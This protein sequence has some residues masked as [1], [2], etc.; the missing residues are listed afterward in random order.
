MDIERFLAESKEYIAK[1]D[2]VQ[3]SEKLYK[4]VEEC[5][6]ILAERY[7]ITE[8]EKAEKEGR[9]R[10]YLLAQAAGRLADK[11][12]RK[13]IEDAWGR[14]FNIHVWGFHEGKFG[15]AEVERNIPFVEQLVDFVR[16]I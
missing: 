15:V 2:A 3:A 12:N 9:W 13:E 1:G 11:L 5:L 16:S 14:A 4:V 7:K 10:S 8:Y 6:K